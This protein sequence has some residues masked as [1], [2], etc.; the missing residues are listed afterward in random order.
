[1]RNATQETSLGGLVKDKRYPIMTEIVEM[2]ERVTEN[3]D[4]W[5][6]PVPVEA[7][8]QT[9][10]AM[11]VIFPCQSSSSGERMHIMWYADDWPRL[12]LFAGCYG[13]RQGHG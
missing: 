5:R 11:A 12:V 2:L 1:M 8:K 4:E 7:D 3:A 13:Q 6:K 10:A 9:E